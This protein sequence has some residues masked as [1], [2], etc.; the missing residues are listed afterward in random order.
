MRRLIAVATII[1]LAL[2]AFQSPLARRLLS[3]K[4]R[5]RA[6]HIEL[7]SDLFDDEESDNPS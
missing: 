7:G 6:G 2:M 1:I 4:W 3:L 5:E